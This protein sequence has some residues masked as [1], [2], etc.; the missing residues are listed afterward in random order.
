MLGYRLCPDGVDWKL[1]A[2]PL[3][4]SPSCVC[5][6]ELTG[7]LSLSHLLA[8]SAFGS[9]PPSVIYRHI[10]PSSLLFLSFLFLFCVS[11]Y[12]KVHTHGGECAC[13]CGCGWRPRVSTGS[14]P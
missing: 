2:L 12:T 4:V 13:A 3:Q 9:A 11:A 8:E 1:S 6:S 14:L 10:C 5:G 7:S